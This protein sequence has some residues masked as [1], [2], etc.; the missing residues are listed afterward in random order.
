MILRNPVYRAYSA[1][2][3]VSKGLKE[4]NTFEKSLSIEEERFIN[5]DTITP[6]IRYKDMGLYY[7]MV[8]AYLHA[9]KDVHI[10]M[11]EDFKNNPSST[12]KKTTEFL[13]V[14]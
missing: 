14:D 2:K 5:D 10:I 8:K 6:M 4:N 13:D 11:Y 9:F 7:N 3:H 1:F 12:M